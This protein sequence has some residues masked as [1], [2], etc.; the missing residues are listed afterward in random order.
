M[1]EIANAFALLSGAIIVTDRLI[2]LSDDQD[3]INAVLFHETGHAADIALIIYEHGD[4]P[5][6]W[7]SD[8]DRK[9]GSRPANVSS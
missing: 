9:H 6:D 4:Y 2:D 1:G 7:G 5:G 8:H 3:Q